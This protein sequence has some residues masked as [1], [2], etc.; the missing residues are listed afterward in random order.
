MSQLHLGDACASVASSALSS[1]AVNL[2]FDLSFLVQMACFAVLIVVLRPLLFD[3]LLQLFE[4]RERRTDGARLLA[5]KMDEEAGE[6][7]QRYE[8]ELEKVRRA[9]SE[10]RERV[11]AEAQRLEAKIL[12][13]A[14]AEAAKIADEGRARIAKEAAA[15]RAELATQAQGIAGAIAARV[16]GREIV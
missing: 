15:T 1:G 10:E 8:S 2:D 6:M 3:P 9:A 5:R 13:E 16:L 7:L 12:A 14:R 4:E 11:R